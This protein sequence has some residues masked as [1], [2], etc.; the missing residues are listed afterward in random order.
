LPCLGFTSRYRDGNVLRM[1]RLFSMFPPGW[2]GL[3]LVLLRVSVAVSVLHDT[4]DTQKELPGWT[5]IALAVLSVTLSAGFLTPMV[6]ML[7]LVVRLVSL[8]G[9]SGGNEDAI[10]MTILSALALAM[11]GPGAYS[12]DAFRFGRRVVVLPPHDPDFPQPQR[13][14]HSA[15]D[16]MRARQTNVSRAWHTCLS[17]RAPRLYRRLQAT[18]ESTNEVPPHGVKRFMTGHCNLSNT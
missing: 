1:Q 12:I 13:L 17:A 5:L 18:P 14:P 3:G 8:I 4:Y 2:P 15:T 16:R 11:L 7:A 6:A 9:V 10:C